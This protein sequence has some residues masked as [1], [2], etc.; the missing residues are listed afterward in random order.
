MLVLQPLSVET[1]WGSTR[2]VAFGGDRAMGRIGQL[3]TVAAQAGYSNRVVGGPHGGQTLREVYEQN[4][5]AF[6]WQGEF[7]L[8]IGFVDAC[9]NL[10]I[11]VHPTDAYAQ[12]H[13]G[14]PYG[15]SE[16]WYFLEPPASG[17][18]YMGTPAAT[19]EEVAAAVAGNRVMDVVGSLPVKRDDYVFVRAGAIHAL[20]AGSLVYEI[21]QS[22]DI[23]YRFYDYDRVDAQ[24]NRRPLHQSQALAVIDPSLTARSVPG[25]PGRAFAEPYYT[26]VRTT[27]AGPWCNESAVFA[28][29]TVLGGSLTVDGQAVTP[30]MSVIALPGELVEF[31]GQADCVIATAKESAQ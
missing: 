26:V 1:I 27:L 30:G 28:C 12:T 9:Q 17:S 25:T 18:I 29:V 5:T 20:T 3:Y 4:P 2:L 21:Q 19:V 10:S 23:T 31:A 15:K 24:G 14:L 7:P 16:S 6:G 13:L 11:Q 8:L 22:T